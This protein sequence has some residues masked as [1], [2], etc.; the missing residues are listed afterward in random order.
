MKTGIE[1]TASL[2]RRFVID[3]AAT[4]H[5]LIPWQR[6]F[7]VLNS[8]EVAKVVGTKKDEQASRNSAFSV[9]AVSVPH[10]Q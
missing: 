10:L 8:E 6:I 4:Q 5:H 3:A 9:Q 1:D 2:N 7:S